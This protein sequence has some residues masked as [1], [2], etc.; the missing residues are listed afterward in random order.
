VLDDDPL[1]CQVLERESVVGQR[2]LAEYLHDLSLAVDSHLEQLIIG[3]HEIARVVVA[4]EVV[5]V[6]GELVPVQE[7]PDLVR[8]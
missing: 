6:V 3:F 7:R 4:D 1:L 8:R 2:E 5:K